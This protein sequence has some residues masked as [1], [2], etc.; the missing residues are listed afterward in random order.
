MIGL[1]LQELGKQLST[2]YLKNNYFLANTKVSII[3]LNKIL[4]VYILNVFILFFIGPL[5]NNNSVLNSSNLDSRNNN[6]PSFCMMQSQ[7]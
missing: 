4:I 6:A 1:Q 5:L 3:R 7:C 2:L